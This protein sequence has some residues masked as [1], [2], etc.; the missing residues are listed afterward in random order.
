MNDSAFS[1]QSTAP[2]SPTL[3][4]ALRSLILSLLINVGFPLLLIYI[5]T[6]Y[7]HTSEFIAL[8]LAS[9]VPI[10]DSVV[11]ILRH[12]R[13]DLIAVFFLLGTS[14]SILALVLG[15]PIQLLIIRESFFSGA[16]GLICL[17]SL[18]VFPRPLMFYV[19][20][21]MLTGNDPVRLQRFNENWQNPTMR[22]SH[23]L[24]TSVWGVALIGEF[25]VRIVL[26]LTLPTTIAFSLGS[27]I[28]TITLAATF[29][30]TFVYI[31]RMRRKLAAT[32]TK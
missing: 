29:F 30:W 15:G 16:L 14:T 4:G 23:R 9:L 28:L 19:G 26:A 25:L 32:E 3:K 10:V 22:A 24:V 13:L 20:R 8:S 18:I 5:L 21:Q 17:L 12:R 7:M 6:T 31:A 2:T 1:K 11:E 27:T